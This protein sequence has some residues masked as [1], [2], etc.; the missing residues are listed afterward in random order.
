[1]AIETGTAT[2][3]KDL[4]TKLKTFLLAQGWTINSF[5]AGATLTD[6]GHLYVTGP[7]SPGGQQPNVSIQTEN[8]TTANAYAWKI[9][10]HTQYDAAAAFGEQPFN[11]PFH[12]FSLWP[13]AI[14]YRFY[15]ND[16]R[17]IVIAKIG[18]VY[19]SMYAG[20]FLPFAL[21]DEYPY[22][23]FIGATVKDLR[24]YNSANAMS[25]S[26]CDPGD[27]AA[28]YLRRLEMNWGTFRHCSN[29]GSIDSYSAGENCVV[30][31]YRVFAVDT[32]YRSGSLANEIFQM[33]RPNADG[34]MPLWQCHLLDS[35][36]GVCA[37]MLDGVYATGG[38]NRVAEQIV[39]D[40]GTDY[41]LFQNTFRTRP[42]D[43][44]AIEEA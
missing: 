8:D 6:L 22:P 12:Y 24:A 36:G 2:D 15:V 42:K 20:F 11:S 3:Y 19:L 26:F 5:A 27:S 25:R 23:Y 29:S 1:M 14:D 28:S 18:T 38:F 40:G 44:F 33:L 13:N 37:G 34:K 9:C 32:D 39:S 43:F 30:W 7:G 35:I 21:P 17:F 41:R 4:L 31:P 10:A 16:R